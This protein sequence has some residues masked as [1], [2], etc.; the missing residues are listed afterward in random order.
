MT[1]EWMRVMGG[2]R[3]VDRLICGAVSACA[4]SNTLLNNKQDL[5][6]R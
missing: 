6:K 3:V 1:D 4:Q 5:L 2:A